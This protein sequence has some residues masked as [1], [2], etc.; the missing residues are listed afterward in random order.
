MEQFELEQCNRFK[1]LRKN[2]KLKQGDLAKALTISQG[3]TSDIENGRK[4]VS[5]RIIEILVLK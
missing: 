1:E 5:D 2:L 3:H 4:A